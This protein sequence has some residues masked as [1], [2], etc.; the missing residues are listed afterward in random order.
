MTEADFFEATEHLKEPEWFRKYYF[1]R[2]D[3]IFSTISK[4]LVSFLI[5]R[6]DNPEFLEEFLT[7]TAIKIYPLEWLEIASERCHLKTL[8]Y[9]LAKRRWRGVDLAELVARQGAMWSPAVCRLFLAS[10]HLKPTIFICAKLLE[11]SEANSCLLE[12]LMAEP[13]FVVFLEPLRK[14]GFKATLEEELEKLLGSHL[15]IGYA[16]QVFRNVDDIWPFPRARL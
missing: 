10:E 14:R 6:Q 3:R 1:T 15:D 12:C 2:P 7:K 5:D 16:R 11:V 8:T 9:L 4:R 13:K